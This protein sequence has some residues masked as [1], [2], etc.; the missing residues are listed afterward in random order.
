MNLYTCVRLTK[1]KTYSALGG[2]ALLALLSSSSLLHAI[3][4]EEIEEAKHVGCVRHLEEKASRKAALETLEKKCTYWRMESQTKVFKKS[5]RI[6]HER[7]F[8]LSSN[9]GK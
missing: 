9:Y 5:S 1:G 6:S 3:P 2:I 7:F 4:P 8:L